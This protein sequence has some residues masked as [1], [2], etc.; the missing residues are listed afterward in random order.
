MAMTDPRYLLVFNAGSSSLKFELFVHQRTWRRDLR[1]AVTNIGRAGSSLELDGNAPPRSVD[2]ADHGEA[3]RIV[4]RQIFDGP[5]A[6]DR[7][8]VLATGHRVVHGGEFFSE[9]ALIEPPVI[10]RLESI[11]DLAP[12]HNPPALKVV[13]TVQQWLP[14]IP[15]V[16]VFDTAFFRDLPEHAAAYA[17]PSDW[18][19]RY[20]IRRYGFHGIAH[21]YLSRRYLSLT[22]SGRTPQRVVSLQLG[23]GCSVTALLD[24]RPVETSMGFTPLEG[25]I[26]GTRAGDLDAGVVLHLARQGVSWQSLE[27]ALNRKSGLLGLSGASDDVRELL[28]LEQT[29]HPGACL[30]MAAF[31]H[32]IHKYVGAYAAVLGGIDAVLFGGGIGEN[33]PMVRSRV[34]KGLEWLGLDVDEQANAACTAAQTKGSETRISSASSTIEVYVIPV[35]EEEAIARATL[36]CIG[37]NEMSGDLSR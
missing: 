3:V 36:A 17:I 15:M 37:E 7:R 19:E 1:G 34:C 10:A 25:L 18:R 11:A 28:Q 8:Q 22:G 13:Q 16:A 9:P 31:C 14:G 33:A 12:L 23:Q 26:M 21:E 4:M 5:E 27:D 32:R 2:A 6:I 24:G 29:Q 30:A 35:R 20:R